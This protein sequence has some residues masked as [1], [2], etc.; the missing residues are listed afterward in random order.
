MQENNTDKSMYTKCVKWVTSA[1]CIATSL[2]YLYTACFGPFSDMI[3]RS[4]LITSC[5]VILFLNKGLTFRKKTNTFTKMVDVLFAVLFAATGIYIMCI[6]RSR[7]LM[8]GTVPVI[9]IVMGTIFIVLLLIVTRRAV[10]NFI[11]A[12]CILLILYALYGRVFPG[13]LAHRGVTWTRFV[14]FSY[15]TS[16]GIFGT[17]A[18]TAASYIILF[19]TFGAFMETLGAGEWFVN[20][21]YALTGR[22]RGGPAKTSVISSALLGMISG[23][24]AANVATTG[25]FTIPLMK[26][27]GYDPLEAGAVEAV[28]STGGLFTPPVMGSAAFIMADNLGIPFSKVALA[29]VIPAALYY[30]SLILTVD[31]IAVK[32]GLRGLPKEELPSVRRS[33]RE[34]GLFL[35]PILGLIIV[36][37]MGW[38]ITKAAFYAIVAMVV[39]AF[40]QKS[41]RQHPKVLL[42]A[43]KKS[44]QSAAPIII[45]CACAGIIVGAISLTGLGA[46]LSYSLITLAHGN[47]YI[48]AGIVMLVTLILGCAMPPTTVYIIVAAVLGRPL[49]DMGIS[50]LCAHMFIFIFSCVGA[51]TPPVA[52][53]AFTAAGISGANANK[54]GFRAFR[55]GLMAFIIP[56]M[57]LC[58]PELLLDA[59]PGTV[60]LATCTAILGVICLVITLEGYFIR[61]WAVCSRILMAFA[62][63]LLIIPGITTDLIGL[64]LL[65]AASGINL[66]M[67]KNGKS[68]TSA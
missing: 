52:L 24:P 59:A 37:V 16:E 17:T 42:T 1:F 60:A 22:Y 58:A 48:A 57:F 64:G 25:T 11:V 55:Y 30:F 12:I 68:N 7:I 26:K 67:H 29:A 49:V 19:V 14:S 63:I 6:W 28:A 8:V 44:T 65:V 21:S 5:G 9:D 3:Q 50:P 34:R 43:L 40:L 66:L 27:V 39:I 61:F 15:I 32:R 38:T 10:G 31:S 35:I 53:A 18:G 41:T 2:V 13:M 20:I 56:F 45:T 23:S 33:M 62:A 46:K 47:P 4:L 36:I 54:T 51:I